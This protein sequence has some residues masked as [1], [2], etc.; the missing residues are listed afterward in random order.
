MTKPWPK[1]I[2]GK[3]FLKDWGGVLLLAII[4]LFGMGYIMIKKEEREQEKEYD[5]KF[6]KIYDDVLNEKNK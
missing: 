4:L 2:W 3:Y 6:R 1:E 5:R